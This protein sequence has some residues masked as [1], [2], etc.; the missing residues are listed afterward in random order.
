MTD[1]DRIKKL[2]PE[3]RL[4]ILSNINQI[5]TMI[6]EMISVD[7]CKNA[8]DVYKRVEFFNHFEKSTLQNKIDLLKIILRNNNPTIFKQFPNF[9][10]ELGEV[11]KMRDSIAHNTVAYEADP[12]GGH[13][14]LLLHHS[15]I[16]KQQ[17][18]TER[19]MKGL[20]KKAEKI[21]QDTRKIWIL[22]G[23]TKSLNFG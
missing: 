15:I 11:K 16:K 20:M 1:L 13:A 2:T 14:K 19:K 18:L 10:I 7:F 12:Q 4:T 17:D 3:F 9:F 21:M 23:N 22:V 6:T 8:N 5:E